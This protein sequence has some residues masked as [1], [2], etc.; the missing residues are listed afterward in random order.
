L[1]NMYG[2][3][4]ST[5]WSSARRITRGD[6]PILIGP[7]IANTQF[8]ILD[9]H[10]QPTPLGTPGELH[11]GGTGLALGYH[12]RAELT[13]EKFIPN[14]FCSELGATLYK[15]GDSARYLS[16]GAIEY[17]GRLDHQV[18]I[19]GFRIELGEIESVLTQFP[20]VRE[21][22]VLARED[23]PG[24]KR[25]VAYFLGKEDIAPADLRVHLESA[26]PDYMLPAAYIRLDALPLTPNG[27]LDRQAL[28]APWDQSFSTRTYEAPEGPNEAAI[29]AIWAEFLHRERVGRHDDFF[30]LG[31]HSLLALRVISQ[32]NKTLNTRLDVPAFFQN[33]TTIERL[34]KAI[35]QNK[36]VERE[37]RVVQL[38]SGRTG[39]PLY[40]VGA[41][42]EEYRMVQLLGEDRAVFA[43]D[44]PMP[45]EWRRAIAAVDKAA[46]P[47]LEQL[48]AL[49]SDVLYAH[50]G[51]SPCVIAGYSLG[52][53]IAFEAVHA[54][55]RAG[56][57]VELVLLIDAWAFTWSGATRG[58]VR[59]SLHR[60]W[61]G[62][63]NGSGSDT[64]HLA[65]LRKILGNSWRLFAW[66]AARIPQM[67]KDRLH[68]VKSR[69]SP[70]ARPSGYLDKEGIPID[71]AAI[72][73][74]AR[75]AGSAWR[76]RPLDAL[77]VLFRAK[78]NS[79]ASLPGYDLSNGWGELFDRGLEI[80]EASGDHISM[81]TDANLPALARQINSVLDRYEA[82]Q[83]AAVGRSGDETG[84]ARLARQPG[85]DQRLPQTEHAIV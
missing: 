70:D 58:P 16:N 80:V 25:L 12:N 23:A 13:A 20:G 15:T 5:I 32:V 31:G 47:T 7:P 55:R 9:Q 69:F 2:P 60:I 53:K 50:V 24:E 6:G 35:E 76:P 74:F 73:R 18:K 83:T 10:L 34:A 39:L 65:R 61:R 51:S 84:A 42:P 56:G 17:L 11:I 81:V 27:K 43:I 30:E 71:Q 78:V 1:W 33:P 82:E 26:L 54:L 8:Y 44:A 22:V 37:P 57:N 63:A 85:S 72:D 41:R 29:A 49:Y 40:F 79:N 75:I 3:T 19:R 59:Q 38:Q 14:P 67:L 45:A 66:L 4:E 68:S 52:G 62:A 64:S 28:P 48:G 21:A 46:L 77:G 36:Y